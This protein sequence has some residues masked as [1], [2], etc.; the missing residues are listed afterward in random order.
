MRWQLVRLIP[1]N[2]LS[3]SGVE[4]QGQP[5]EFAGNDIRIAPKPL[6]AAALTRTGV[7][8]T[9][10]TEGLTEANVVGRTDILG[11]L[12]TPN[13]FN[14][15][16]LTGNKVQPLVFTDDLSRV[17]V[18]GKGVVYVIDT[19]SFKLISTIEIEG[20]KNIVSLAT[21]GNLL[22]IGEGSTYGSGPG[23]NRLLVMDI[24]PGSAHY[25]QALSLK[26]TGVEQSKY[27]VSGMTV[28]PDGHTLVVAVPKQRDSVA[29]AVS[30]FG[31]T[32]DVLIFDLNTVNFRTGNIAAPVTAVLPSDG[33]SGKAPQV[34]T[35]TKDADHYL[36]GNVKDYNRGL[37]TLDLTRDAEGVV[38]SAVMTHID[39]S[40]PGRDIVRD[41]LD[42]QRAQSAVLV[43][44]KGIEYAI[45]ADDNY[46]FNDPYFN[47]M[48]EAPMFLIPPMG[49]PI[50]FGGS[51]SA[52]RVAVGG[53]L[54][55][56][57][58]PFGAAQFIG[59]TLP[60]AGYGITNLSVSPD[61]LVLIG[62]LKGG[63]DTPFDGTQNP[64]QSHAWNVG[65]LLEAA[66]AHPEEQRMRKHIV[67]PASAEL[68][69]PTPGAAPAGT[70]FDV[71]SVKVNVEGRL[72]D[73]IQVDLKRQVAHALLGLPAP[74]DDLNVVQRAAIAALQNKINEIMA[75]L[76]D[77]NLVPGE[78]E[79]LT[80]RDSELTRQ[81][82]LVTKNDATKTI[83]SDADGFY[84]SGL[85]YLAPN[86]TA[87]DMETLRQGGVIA[88][89]KTQEIMLTYK[90]KNDITI[91]GVSTDRLKAG[92]AFISLKVTAKDYATAQTTFFGDRPL[93]N[94][95]YTAFTLTSEVALN[96]KG[97]LD[98]WRVEQR[99][100][101][102]GYSAFGTNTAIRTQNLSNGGTLNVPK[103]FKVD[104]VIGKEEQSALQAIYAETHYKYYSG[105]NSNGIQTAIGADAISVKSGSDNFNWLNAY[106]A[107]HWV[108][109]YKALG[110]PTDARGRL[111][112]SGNFIDGTTAKM[113]IYS[114]SWTLD[115]LKA[116]EKTKYQ[117][118]SQQLISAST[119]LQLNGLT[120]PSYGDPR[121]ANGGHS[122]GMGIDLGVGP[123]YIIK[124][125]Q[126]DP[127][128]AGIKPPT[129]SGSGVW[130]I[131]NAKDLSA[132]PNLPNA[133]GNRQQDALRNFLSLYAVTQATS[134]RG[135]WS[136]ISLKYAA[137]T[138][139][140]GSGNSD[141]QQLIQNV[142][143]GSYN[144]NPYT[145]I[146][147][148]LG[149]L[150]FSGA[151]NN[152][153]LHHGQQPTHQ[154]HFHV[155]LRAPVRVGIT[156]NLLADNVTTD[157]VAPVANEALIANAQG[158]LE[159]AR[160]DLN[161]TQG[162]VLMFIPDM[163]NVPPQEVPVLIAQANQAQ[164]GDVK[165]MRTL[166]V[167]EPVPNSNYSLEN[168][169]S[170]K[171]SA[172]F[173]LRTFEHQS[174]ANTDPAT[175]TILQQPKHGT[176]RLVT[177]A[178]VGTILESGGDPVNPADG[179]YFYLPENG[180]L[181]KDSATF[182]VEIAGVKV[183]VVYFLQAIQGPL[184]NTGVEE[185][186]GKRGYRWKISSTL[187]TNG[188]STLTAVTYQSNVTG[189]DTVVMP[190]AAPITLDSLL[191]GF[192]A[193]ASG[194]SL[195]ITDLPNGALG[196][197]TGTTI[198]LD[199][200]A[201]GHGWFIDTTPGDNA[202]FLPT[203][204]PNE[205]IAK[206]GSAAAGKLDMLSVLLHE[207]GHVLGIDHS[208][209]NHDYMAT[210][211]TPGVRRLPS[212]DELALMADLVVGLKADLQMAASDGISTSN[213]SDNSPLPFPWLP[214]D[215][216][217]GLAFLGRLRSRLS[218]LA[219]D[220]AALTPTLSQGEREV[221]QY[222]VVANATLVNGNLDAA[223]G[224]LSQGSVAFANGTAVLNEV[225]NSQTRLSQVFM[226]G[227][228]DRFLS[229]TLGGTVLDD[230]L[231]G[232]DDA[233]EAALLD[234]NTGASLAGALNLSRTDAL[235][236]RHG[237]RR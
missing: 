31:E 5:L 79:N 235:F 106:N 143:I 176:L 69:I 184:G 130:N 135:T 118:V 186:C 66:L 170:P 85:M 40:Q 103:E 117:L 152:E 229:F 140:F 90:L 204:N 9:R 226:V 39:M 57:Q 174:V 95:G 206:E 70:F 164:A 232:P 53:K 98:V 19:L 158:L 200:N 49:V 100:K 24:N 63:Y 179:L 121:H 14:G 89:G 208:A 93:N 144:A 154:S 131:Q 151:L 105:S 138:A 217:L 35:A 1:N 33:H 41:R 161:L 60:L 13:N 190:T 128:N 25:N 157:Q 102:L 209:D 30:A 43:T 183:K 224:W 181:G 230:Q 87:S 59:A 29:R 156:Q 132:S 92:N 74:S 88:G 219:A 149:A 220:N 125:N 34:I 113:E 148:V 221:V 205:W 127:L 194:V 8:F 167:C 104:G 192:V 75:N 94:P 168:V 21:V 64:H 111:S 160:M 145:A 233:F 214:L 110:I 101:Y 187:D 2:G 58:D 120:D 185:Y 11:L 112:A 227:A 223:T 134:A 3:G 17:Y 80:G 62:Q 26:N 55:I 86:L 116:W 32:G 172:A 133:Q 215:S 115:L 7:V 76:A 84:K 81:M 198:T 37:S 147:D 18:G 212:P 109:V 54:G 51:A 27:G 236:R 67:V 177:Q 72:G 28:G 171:G 211:L 163:P 122:V 182:L 169:F 47:A 218:G 193:N 91:L 146:N 213:T 166:G 73:I 36:V 99:L 108:N 210:T 4:I 68:L 83:I 6:M 107:P 46:N 231:I 129:I 155:D 16:Y 159:Q 196:Q 137:T 77:F 124:D 42:I 52:K 199:D 150:G 45:V 228:Q 56:I 136:D 141:S 12:G 78:K 216:T 23:G 44:Y 139:L 119:R 123:T 20:G 48:F 22:I 50:A 97:T 225:S 65:T 203:H 15:T 126:D 201:A 234:A 71:D 173:Y 202:E 10:E 189:E 96:S 162:E 153:L 165:T 237:C 38:T 178:D 207:Y 222:D 197:T 195:N 82:S 114:T 191:V 180:Y 188:N 61:G 175:V 142:W